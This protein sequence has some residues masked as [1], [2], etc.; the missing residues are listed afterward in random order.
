MIELLFLITLTF[1]TRILFRL[2]RPNATGSDVYFHL[3]AMNNINSKKLP[4]FT[5][6]KF[7]IP[8]LI[9][10][11][12]SYLPKRIR[13]R[14]Y[15]FS[16][17]CDSIY[18]G[19]VF[20]FALYLGINP[21]LAGLVFMFMPILFKPDARTYFF[22]P[23]PWAELLFSASFI[24]VI[25]GQMIPAVIF[26]IML[27]HS[28]KFGTQ[29]FLFFSLGMMAISFD[30]ILVFALS[31]ALS[32]L[33]PSYWKMIR[34]H[35]SHSNFYRT[36]I[37]K[38]HTGCSNVANM[39]D[40]K[41]IRSLFRNPLFLSLVFIPFLPFILLDPIF[42]A[43]FVWILI[44]F[45]TMLLISTKP[46]RFLG[47]AERYLNY[48]ILPVCILAVQVS[49]FY[50]ILLISIILV[51]VNIHTANKY[52]PSVDPA[53]R[54]MFYRWMNSL[55]PHRTLCI[56][57]NLSPEI[58]YNSHHE[59]VYWSG[60]LPD[61]DFGE[62]EWNDTFNNYPYPKDDLVRIAESFD[63]DMLVTV[64]RFTDRQ[65][66]FSGFDLIFQNNEY[67]AYRIKT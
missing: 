33:N 3:H 61:K 47:R 31:L 58:A 9:H 43:Y 1:S 11:I 34:G 32:L 5:Y 17:I 20:F 16:P 28:S 41:N 59:T 13:E 36:T 46:L 56:P 10:R 24:C 29:V 23:R 40:I 37:V 62:K 55:K 6:S 57:F 51:G 27:L 21:L 35:I 25:I 39:R 66:D 63:T 42:D 7:N 19:M 14:D 50:W 49:F 45:G 22:S 18:V 64:C 30:F 53:Q 44:A 8:P 60:N 67:R 65:Y 52:I 2:L 48:A 12:F 54:R 4:R 15:I 26:G 38:T